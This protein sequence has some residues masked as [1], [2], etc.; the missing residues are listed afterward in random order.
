VHA[1]DIDITS[2][3][4]LDLRERVRGPSDCFHC[5]H[6]D[7]HVYVL[8]N[9]LEAEA[10]DV[11]ARRGREKLCVAFVH[12]ADGQLRFRDTPQQV[13]RASA[14]ALSLA[15]CTPHSERVEAVDLDGLVAKP[16]PP[17]PLNRSDRERVT[18]GPISGNLLDEGEVQT[19]A[20]KLM[21]TALHTPEIDMQKVRATK[22]ARKKRDRDVTISLC[23][24]PDGKVVRVE[25][26]RGDKELTKL[27]I[28][29]VEH[30]RFRR[31]VEAQAVCT[32]LHFKFRFV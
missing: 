6:C 20:A 3:C 30:W 31:R 28:E 22:A 11:L 24:D 5:E 14:M 1:D 9:M 15:A 17:L 18:A 13:L 19:A 2:P 23:V 29:N 10:T 26:V 25:R 32:E 8:S 7:R 21:A 12:G 16:P 27:L 4:P